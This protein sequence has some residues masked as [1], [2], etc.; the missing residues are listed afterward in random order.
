MQLSICDLKGGGFIFNRKLQIGNCKWVFEMM[1]P[2]TDRSHYG[3]EY[4]ERRRLYSM[5]VQA[6]ALRELMPGSVLE[7]GPGLGVFAAMYRQLSGARVVTLDIDS[8]LRP[9]VIGSVFALPFA[10]AAFD[11]GAC[12][13]MLEHLPFERFAP[14]LREIGRVA[15]V[16]MALSLPDCSYALTVRLGIRNP[17]HDGW[18]GAWTLVP[19]ALAMRKMK[20]TPNT[21]GHYWEIGRRG[22][23][24]AVVRQEIQGAGWRIEK[25]FRTPENAY[26]RFFVLRKE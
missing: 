15:K 25:E 12:F 16:G 5:A 8:T 2:Q 3:D 22:T 21:A 19:A 17:R 23:P 10:D 11:A 18:T 26:H 14:A 6:E 20:Q 9:D 24:L 4:Y 7:I 1:Q 13:Q